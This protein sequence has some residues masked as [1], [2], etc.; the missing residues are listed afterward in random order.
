MGEKRFM[1]RITPETRR[2][3]RRPLGKVEAGAC[4]RPGSDRKGIL[5]AVG[6]FCA[7]RLIKCGEKPDI[8]VFDHKC[9]RR[10]VGRETR[11]VLDRYMGKGVA[12]A[13]PPGFITDM[14]VAEVKRALKKG[15]G[16]I[17]VE[18]EEDLAALVALMHAKCGTLVAYGQ[19][20][21]GMVLVKVDSPIRRR[22]RAIFEK[23][24]KE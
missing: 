2:I 18:G 15:R 11:A 21:K 22:A 23:M 10:N 20:K 17:F 9:M 5:V 6:D 19:P 12:V 1:R 13:N 16:K 24:K 7:F 3:L 8:V 4:V 14:L